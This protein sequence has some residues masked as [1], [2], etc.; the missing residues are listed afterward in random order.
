MALLGFLALGQPVQAQEGDC[1]TGLVEFRTGVI[2]STLMMDIHERRIESGQGLTNTR[3]LPP[4]GGVL[5]V[6][7]FPR[8]NTTIENSDSIVAD[9]MTFSEDGR[10]IA[11]LKDKS[12]PQLD[13]MY[14]GDGVLYA[15]YLAGG[16]IE[17]AALDETTEL[18]G[19]DCMQWR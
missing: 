19:W 7:S 14:G 13:R 15:A 5:S 17:A 16:T 11:L 12:G 3:N 10:A 8:K 9:M 1:L 18:V 6:Y 4:M 2:R